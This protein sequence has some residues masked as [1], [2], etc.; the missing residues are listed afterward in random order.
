MITENKIFKAADEI[1]AVS[2]TYLKRGL[3]NNLKD[4]GLVVYLGTDLKEFDN[5]YSNCQV[6]KKLAK[7]G[8]YML[9]HWDI[10]II[11]RLLLMQ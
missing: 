7:Y 6:I 10:A 9:G 4:N 2:D 3:K 5:T 1:I 8:L 11:L